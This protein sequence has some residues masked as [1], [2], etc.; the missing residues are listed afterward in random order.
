MTEK[1]TSFQD[2]IQSTTPVLVDFYADWCGP[3]HAMNPVLK[4]LAGE[5]QEQAKIV[6]IDV[7]K[8]PGVANDFGVQ[9]IPTYIV[10]KEGE[11]KWRGAG[12]MPKHQLKQVLTQNV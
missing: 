8:N 10:F 9:S 7:D 4:E 5:M 1:K 11:V 2:L 3:C 6:K 12:V